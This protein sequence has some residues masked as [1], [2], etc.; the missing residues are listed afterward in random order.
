MAIKQQEKKLTFWQLNKGFPNII[1][2]I[3]FLHFSL[4]GI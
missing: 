4:K 3:A 2:N 1:C